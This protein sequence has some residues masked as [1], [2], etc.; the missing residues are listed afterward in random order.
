MDSRDVDILG[1]YKI[2]RKRAMINQSKNL[3][4][5][6]ALALGLAACGFMPV[7]TA[8]Q[9]SYTR[10]SATAKSQAGDSSSTAQQD[11]DAATGSPATPQATPQTGNPQSG[12]SGLAG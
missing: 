3:L 6:C 5:G 10:N 1:N 12:I 4:K 2:K 8:A 7:S 9:E 11:I